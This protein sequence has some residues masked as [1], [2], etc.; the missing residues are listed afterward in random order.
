MESL[1]AKARAF[2]G[3]TVLAGLA[4]SAFALGQWQ[5]TDP[6]HFAAYFLLALLASGVKLNLPGVHST[7]SLISLFIL[8]GVIQLGF[9]E[10]VLMSIAGTL[11]QCYWHAKKPPKIVHV[12]FSVATTTA[13][14]VDWVT[15]QA[16]RFF[17]DAWAR[18]RDG[19]PPQDRDGNLADA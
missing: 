2:I 18:F 9:P 4:V 19:A 8:V 13:R 7:F 3:A 10:L 16:G 1:S 15:R 12:L 14:E 5:P 11:M 17:P 6:V